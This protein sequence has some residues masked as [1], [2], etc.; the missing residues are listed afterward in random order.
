[1]SEEY[2]SSQQTELFSLVK[3]LVYNFVSLILQHLKFFREEAKEEAV[4][5]VKAVV[6]MWVAACI[7]FIASLFFGIFLVI[8]LSVFISFWFSIFIVTLLYILIPVI[9]FIVAASKFK[10]IGKRQKKS[11]EEIAK[12]LEETKKW[13]EQL[14]S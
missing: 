8:T 2:S 3:N 5:F 4:T 9:L 14:K 11:A 10:K 7:A 6:I 1:M 12:T 13:L